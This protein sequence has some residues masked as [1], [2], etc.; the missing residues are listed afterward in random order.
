MHESS[1]YTLEVARVRAIV[2]FLTPGSAFTRV[3]P[4]PT[5]L[6]KDHSLLLPLV[7][8]G[9]FTP[10]HEANHEATNPSGPACHLDVRHGL[11]PGGEPL[12][13]HHGPDVEAGDTGL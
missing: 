7:H 3:Q 12:R 4:A 9:P 1:I 11:G 10:P 6:F 13:H 2:W 5:S 8:P